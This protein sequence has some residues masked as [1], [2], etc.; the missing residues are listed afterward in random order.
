M[1]C[2]ACVLPYVHG[3]GTPPSLLALAGRE[4]GCRL[5]VRL[6]AI[7]AAAVRSARAATQAD[8][9]PGTPAAGVP[10]WPATGLVV[11]RDDLQHPPVVQLPALVAPPGQAHRAL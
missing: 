2:Q 7:R 4:P 6:P 5:V 3:C 8:R 10:R 11:G 9:R 1:R